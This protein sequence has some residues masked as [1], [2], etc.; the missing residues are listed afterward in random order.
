MLTPLDWLRPRTIRVGVTGLARAGKTAFLTSVAANLLAQGAGIPALPSLAGR[1]KRVAL[2]PAGAS[3]LVRFDHAAHLAALDADPP[4]WPERTASVALLA[5]ELEL[6]HPVLPAR[7]LR[8]ELL[9]YPGEWLLDLPLLEQDFGAWSAAT[10]R[11]LQAPE[12]AG[13]AREFLGFTAALPARAPADEALA[14]SGHAL[15]VALLRRLRDELGLSL[16]QPGRFLMPPPGPPPPWIAFFPSLAGGAFGELL[17]ARFGACQEAVRDE[18]VSPLFGDLDRIVVLADLLGALHA[19]EAA[20]ADAKA[21]LAASAEALRWRGSWWEAAGSL[22]RGRLPA[23]VIRRVAYAATKADHVADRQRGN[24]RALV[25]AIAAPPAGAAGGLRTASFAIASVRCTEDFVWTLEGH[26][27]SAVRGRRIGDARMTRSYPG[28]VPD[29]PPSPAFW[30]HPFL[31]LP[32]FE[33]MRLPGGGRAGVAN[34]GLDALLGFL[35]E[36]VL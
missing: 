36:D 27:V 29:T 19:G 21:A 23:R 15:Y 5:L 24:L 28:E 26:P 4:G 22:A 9:D 1:L 2:A 7:T 12:L 20:F 16:L 18:M 34:I 14:A 32:G 3:G 10:L 17:A 31:S 11:R 33:P 35:L 6:V 25:G 30:A 8:L 13:L